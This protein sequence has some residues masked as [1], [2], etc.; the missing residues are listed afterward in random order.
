MKR[1]PLPPR[2]APLR[3]TPFKVRALPAADGVKARK[4]SGL[5]AAR[6]ESFGR[7]GGLCVICVTE[8]APIVRVATEAHHRKLK[9]QGGTDEAANLLPLCLAHHIP[10]VHHYRELSKEQGWIVPMWDVV[11]P[12]WELPF[13]TERRA[14]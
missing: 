12:W 3:R 13:W 6:R 4:R 2:S 5:D 11:F 8:G 14:S 9:S 7:S 10:Y 1:A